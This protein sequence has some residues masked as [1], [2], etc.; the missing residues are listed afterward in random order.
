M[1]HHLTDCITVSFSTELI[2]CAL[3]CAFE[4]ISID[5]FDMI[6]RTKNTVLHD[7]GIH[8][9]LKWCVQLNEILLLETAA[10][11][12][13]STFN[14]SKR[15]FFLIRMTEDVIV[16]NGSIFTEFPSTFRRSEP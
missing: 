3:F 8:V 4:W 12:L 2:F 13:R 15:S 10:N 14:S 16:W 5:D 11:F 7:R 9:S 6:P 1:V